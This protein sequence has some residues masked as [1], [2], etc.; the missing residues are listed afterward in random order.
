MTLGEQ[1]RQA[2]EKKNLS[3]EE[4]AAQVGVSRQAVSK[5]EN[6]ASV[7]QGL[8]RDILKEI[9][10]LDSLGTETD[11]IPAEELPAEEQMPGRAAS[12]NRILF[13]LAAVIL[14]AAAGLLIGSFIWGRDR[15]AEELPSAEAIGE[16]GGEAADR[17][18]APAVKSVQFY[19]MYDGDCHPTQEHSGW[20]NLADVDVI[21]IQWEGE[22]PNNIKLLFTAAG[23]DTAG[24]TRLLQTKPVPAGD[25]AVLFGAGALGEE[26]E[27]SVWFEL[28]YGDSALVS[29]KYRLFYEDGSAMEEPLPAGTE[30]MLAYITAFKDGKLT[31]DAAEWVEVPG[32]RAAELGIGENDAGF[33][34]YNGD[35]TPRELP[36]AEDCVFTVLDWN[37]NY[38]EETVTADRFRELLEERAGLDVPYTLTIEGDQIVHIEEHYVP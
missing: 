13:L 5:W 28:D 20:Y 34:V 36:L 26:R 7:P 12:R 9:L 31:F 24:E 4:L 30:R 15:Q 29:E 3:Q 1:I 16:A 32:S 11:D 25:S 27:G 35:D 19:G 6:D 10:G 33:S 38:E 14:S 18:P 37:H 17:I 23:T 2:R 21:L 8:N 22:S